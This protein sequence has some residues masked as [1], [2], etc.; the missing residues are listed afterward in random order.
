MVIELRIMKV[1]LYKPFPFL[2]ETPISGYD[3][4]SSGGKFVN[5][6]N[7][8]CFLQ[9]EDGLETENHLRITEISETGISNSTSV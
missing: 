2:V 5:L 1:L 7:T 4:P 6:D 3:D 8:V 9:D